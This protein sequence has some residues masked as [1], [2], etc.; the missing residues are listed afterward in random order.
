MKLKSFLLVA[1]VAGMV[2]C[3]T[4]DSLV[5]DFV[6]ACEAGDV[7]EMVEIDQKIN[8]LADEVG[9]EG[10]TD[11]HSEKINKA[12]GKVSMEVLMEYDKLVQEARKE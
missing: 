3:T 10:F 4:P 2:A 1:L 6:A 11:E 12:L 5:E 7:K 9:D 8:E